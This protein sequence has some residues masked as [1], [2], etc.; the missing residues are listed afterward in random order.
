MQADASAIGTLF[1][2]IV[3]RERDLAPRLLDRTTVERLD[4]SY[5]EAARRWSAAIWAAAEVLGPAAPTADAVERGLAHA[6]RPVF[7]CGAHRSGTTL[8]RDLLDGHPALAVLPFETSFYTHFRRHQASASAKEQLSSMGQEWLRRLVNPNNQAPFWLLGHSHRLHSPYVDLAQAFQGWQ[9]TLERR[10]G[11]SP[12]PSL[13]IAFA[14]AYAGGSLGSVRM[15]V[16]KTPTN[17]Q[18]LDAI[19]ADFPA[20]RILHVIRR[21]E[22]A[23][24]SHKA[25]RSGRSVRSAAREIRN[26][27]RSYAVAVERSRSLSGSYHLVRYEDLAASPGAVMDGVAGFLGIEP[28]AVLTRPTVAGLPAGRNTSFPKGRPGPAHGLG[29]LERVLLALVLGRNAARLGYSRH[30]FKRRP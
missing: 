7:I 18:F 22:E 6:Q 4:L 5:V 23:Y 16:E 3:E 19:L 9:D 11:G 27:A 17:E 26:L 29:R 10:P 21:P 13:L 1:E 30:P 8:L 15:W 28:L 24:S 20:A 25:L 12:P 14:L 2:R